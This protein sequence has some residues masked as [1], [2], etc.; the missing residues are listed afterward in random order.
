MYKDS[1]FCKSARRNSSVGA[2][3]SERLRTSRSTVPA[4]LP[5][6]ASAEHLALQHFRCLARKS[7]AALLVLL[8]RPSLPTCRLKLCRCVCLPVARHNAFCWTAIRCAEQLRGPAE[9]KLE[10]ANICKPVESVTKAIL[11]QCRIGSTTQA[12][13]HCAARTKR[14]T[15]VHKTLLG[16]CCE[17]A[18][19][20]VLSR[21]GQRRSL[22]LP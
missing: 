6:A 5:A 1:A 15:P 13:S 10:S 4:S 17:L 16:P 20:S 14:H 3:L 11:H 8:P 9:R 21:R 22:T 18:M 19:E 12:G 2:H 7:G